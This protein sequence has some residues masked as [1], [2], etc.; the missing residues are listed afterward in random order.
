VIAFGL[1]IPPRLLARA[2]NFLSA[3]LDRLNS[4]P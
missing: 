2:G 1:D 3:K 4:K